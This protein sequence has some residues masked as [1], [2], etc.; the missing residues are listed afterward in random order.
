MRQ[1]IDLYCLC[2]ND[3]RM[4]PYFF[5]HY[6]DM[7]DRYFVL[8]NG[9]TDGSLSLLEG[10]GRVEITHFDVPGDSFVEEERRLADTMWQGSDADWVIV[11]EIDEHLYRPNLAEYLRRC[12]TQGITAIRSIGYEMVSDT[13]PT[14]TRPLVEQVTVGARSLPHD[15][16]CIFNPKEIT[17]TN[18]GLGRHTADPAGR[19]VWPDNREV[20]LLHYKGVGMEY[21]IARSAELRLGLK[22]RDLEEGWGVQYTWSPAEITARWG[23]VKA[24]S[25]PVPGLGVLKHIE[26]AK[27]FEEQR[28]VELSGLFDSEWYMANYPDVE[29]MLCAPVVPADALS[30][31]CAHGW[32]QGRQPNF[33]FDPNWYCTTYP[34]MHTAGRN[35]LRDYL[36]HGEKEGASP[37]PR[38]NTKWYRDEH[39]LPIEESPLQHYLS[40]RKVGM[41]SPLPEFDVV[42]YCQRHPKVL[43]VGYDPFEHYCNRKPRP[44]PAVVT[45]TKPRSGEKK[46][47]KRRR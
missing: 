29:R 33:Y 31:Y 9:S 11:I 4:L 6:D 5:Q 38:F 1:R 18:F 22:E 41:V 12:T 8:D 27:Y 23:A 46:K 47:T 7:V 28:I 30:H 39:H 43:A 16:L 42:K 3:A 36:E 26:P 10:H 37:S 15:R 19:V 24:A 2:W 40:R 44:H 14:R 25:G 45:R 35:P 21:L 17:E 20:L 34:E 13:F 32:E